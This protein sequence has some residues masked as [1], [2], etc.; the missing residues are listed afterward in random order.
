MHSY[1]LRLFLKTSE[2][3]DKYNI[4]LLTVNIEFIWLG[5]KRGERLAKSSSFTPFLSLVKYILYL[6]STDQYCIY[7]CFYILTIASIIFKVGYNHFIIFQYHYF[8]KI[9]VLK[10]WNFMKTEF[11][12]N[13]IILNFFEIFL[14]LKFFE[15]FLIL[16]FFENF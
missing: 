3:Q 15:I 16:K 13:F 6:P 14:I 2:L 1:E 8:L 4:G 7:V 11:F 9:H 12:W 5:A 10:F